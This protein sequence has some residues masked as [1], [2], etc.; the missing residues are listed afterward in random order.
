[1]PELRVAARAGK[2]ADVHERSD[3]RLRQARDEL[4]DGAGAVAD[5][6]DAAVQMFET[7]KRP[8]MIVL[9]GSQT[10]R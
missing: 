5:R 7:V 3:A 4:L 10:S 9:C 8:F 6:V 2:A 1:L